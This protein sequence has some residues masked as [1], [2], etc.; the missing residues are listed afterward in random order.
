MLEIHISQYNGFF[1]IK[2]G[3]MIFIGLLILTLI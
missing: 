1:R 3:Y 2:L